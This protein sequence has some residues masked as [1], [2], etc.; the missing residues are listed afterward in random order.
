MRTGLD[1][2]DPTRCPLASMI[3]IS[4]AKAGAATP[5][6][7]TEGLL[8]IMVPVI[9]TGLLALNAVKTPATISPIWVELVGPVPPFR[10]TDALD[11]PLPEPPPLP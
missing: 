1:A 10:P 2:L 4:V 6:G 3:P 5:V 7:P 11:P 9:G 8:A